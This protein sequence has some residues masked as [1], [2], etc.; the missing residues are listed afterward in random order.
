MR[1]QTNLI[2]LVFL[3]FTIL[4]SCETDTKQSMVYFDKANSMVINED[5][6][7]AILE[8]NKALQL[9]SKNNDF[10]LL[11]ARIYYLTSSYEDAIIVLENI[12]E[13][14]F[15]KDTINYEIAVIYFAYASAIEKNRIKG[16][17]R[18][19]Y[20][21]AIEYL[22]K[23]IKYNPK[24]YEAYEKKYKT[25]HNLNKSKE[26]L[27]VINTVIK[28]FP[29]SLNLIGFRGIEKNELG[30]Y[31]GALSD[32]SEVIKLRKNIDSSMVSIFY[33]FRGII[34]YYDLDSTD[35][36]ISDLTNAITYDS[37]ND[38]GYLSRAAV[39]AYIGKN[40]KAC[41]DYHKAANLGNLSVYEEISKHCK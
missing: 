31:N 2:Y 41:A 18:L 27:F 24:Y 12:L 23:A 39:Y 25:L 16:D 9:D 37:I 6:S 33:R 17:S 8:I 3:L 40:D 1:K 36:A 20:G 5:Y 14:D 22:S 32:L 38:Q 35:K 15:K 13:M 30:D 34:Y 19:L 11:K 21:K 29:D 28:L 4:Q 26:A 7:N 10:Y